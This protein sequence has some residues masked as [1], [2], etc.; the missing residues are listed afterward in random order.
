MLS[1][2]GLSSPGEEGELIASE[3]QDG[4]SRAFAHRYRKLRGDTLIA[5]TYRRYPYHAIRSDIAEHVL[6]KDKEALRRITAV[7]P[8]REPAQ[9][10][11]IGYERR[12]LESYLNVLIQSSVTLLCE[13]RRKAISRKYGFSKNTLARACDGVGIRYEHLP[14]LGIE[15]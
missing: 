5:E 3:V 1:P 6:G 11:T 9:L 10:S 4:V 13:V 14:E 12:T 2:R 15:S 7:Q 8:Q